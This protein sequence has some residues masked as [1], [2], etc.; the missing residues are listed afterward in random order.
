MAAR[1]DAGSPV[2]RSAPEFHPGF[3]RDGEERRADGLEFGGGFL[4]DLDFAAGGGGFDG[5]GAGEAQFVFHEGA[6]A[7]P[8]AK[9]AG[10][11]QRGEF[12]LAGVDEEEFGAGF[13]EGAGD[14]VV[15]GADVGVTADDDAD[16]FVRAG[17]V[18]LQIA[19]GR[20]GWAG[21]S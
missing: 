6:V 17:K 3:L 19:V 20:R 2:G 7:D 12:V 21:R 15:L 1:G 18:A 16:L 13:G 5:E 11:F 4:V 8:E 10:G 14:D 9:R